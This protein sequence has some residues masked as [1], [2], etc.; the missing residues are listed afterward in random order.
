MAKKK[1]DSPQISSDDCIERALKSL[2]KEF[3]PGRIKTGRQVIDQK[4]EVF[5]F[6]PILDTAL[7]GGVPE[8]SWVHISGPPKVGK[9]CAALTLCADAQKKGRPVFYIDVEG[10][11]KEKELSGIEGLD[12]DKLTVVGPE[13]GRI[14]TSKDYLMFA[15]TFI[16]DVPRSVVILDSISALINPSVLDEERDKA[17][18]GSGNKIVGRFCDVCAQVVPVNKN[19]VVGI[20]HFYANVSGYGKANTEKAATR[21]IYQTDIRLRA[22]P[23][24]KAWTINKDGE[25]QIGQIVSWDIDASA[26]GPP[27]KK[28][29]SYLRYGVGIDRKYELL[30]QAIEIGVVENAG[31]WY[32][33]GEQKVQGAEN[34]YNM[35]RENAEL[36]TAIEKAVHESLGP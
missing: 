23:G 20:V 36:F 30:Q 9:S 4:R 32:T 19:I 17:D 5:S 7:S 21:W 3:G 12:V 14:L 28:V 35:M 16:K 2:E 34:L 26:L 33:F 10:R 22:N 24:P 29:E 15:E 11:I 13:E 31:S 8:G 25:K 27:I 6:S 18:Y 1:T